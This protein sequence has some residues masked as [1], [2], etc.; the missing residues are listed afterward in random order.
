MNSREH[1]SKT[2]ND[3]Q[4]AGHRDS[5][6][7]GEPCFV[8]GTV[9][10]AGGSRR[11]FVPP[12]ASRATNYWQ[13]WAFHRTAQPKHAAPRVSTLANTGGP[14]DGARSALDGPE[15]FARADTRSGAP[16]F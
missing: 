9:S 13:E 1:D 6:K 4:G 5:L 12:R 7:P 16:R 15:N 10:C 11:I 14:T 8:I 2:A 3:N